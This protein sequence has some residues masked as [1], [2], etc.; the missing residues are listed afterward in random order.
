[1]MAGGLKNILL[2]LLL[3]CTQ[4]VFSQTVLVKASTDKNKILLGEPFWLTLQVMAP[5]G[6]SIQPFKIDS[7][8]HFEFLKKDSIIKISEGGTTIIRQYYQLTS[9][10]SGRWVIPQFTLRPFVKTQSLLMDV[11][12]TDPFDPNQPYH[13]I[14]DLRSAPFKLSN[15]FEKWWYLIALLLIFITLIIYWLT[16]EKK[17]KPVKP[18]LQ[19]SP[20][21]KALHGLQELKAAQ[22]DTKVLYAGLVDI[23]REYVLNR[24]GIESL[25]QTSTDLVTKLKPLFKEESEGTKYTAISQV[26]FLSDFV[27][28]A[29]Y[30]PSDSEAI[31]AYEVVRQSIDHIEEKAERYQQVVKPISE[32]AII[33][34]PTGQQ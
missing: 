17:P 13:D 12:F 16:S 3:A 10:D 29:K 4:V 7:I 20:Y 32:S 33:S 30:N 1:M 18:V 21:Q 27:K 5:A 6:S 22:T 24:T 11:V 2:L 19:E 34:G 26:L 14:Q 9:F 23:F 28:F 31:S 25:Q 8:A 15:D